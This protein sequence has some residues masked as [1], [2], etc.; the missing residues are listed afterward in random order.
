MK[1]R[2]RHT[3]TLAAAAALALATPVLAQVQHEC[4]NGDWDRRID[5]CT[6]L[7]ATPGLETEAL[8]SA[9]ASRALAFSLRGQHDI[10]IND[11]DE[12]IRLVPN[13]AIALNNRA[14][15]YFKSGRAEK[16][17]PDVER[18]LHLDP[19]SSHAY[20]TRAHIRQWTGDPQGALRDYDAAIRFG[21]ERMIE[22][23]QCGLHYHR[24]YTGPADGI[25]TPELRSALEICVTRTYCDPLP[26]DEVCRPAT[27]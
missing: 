6:D 8:S 15:A 10:A 25:W 26:P 1:M 17:R 23:Y 4:H 7:I 5:A 2:K 24:L 22:L 20:D 13:F 14:W 27:S 12:A 19:V 11:Y 16:G 9:Y 18:S 3:A 21:G